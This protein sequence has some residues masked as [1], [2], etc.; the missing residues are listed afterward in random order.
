V[1]FDADVEQR[2]ERG[3]QHGREPLQRLDLH[4]VAALDAVD[5]RARNAELR[6]NVLGRQAAANAVSLEPASDFL[7]VG[8]DCVSES[9]YVSDFRRG[10]QRWQLRRQEAPDSLCARHKA[11]GGLPMENAATYPSLKDRV[12]LVTG[13]AMGIGEAIVRAF[14]R[15]Q[16]R[17]GFLDI[18]DDAARKLQAEI[19]ATAKLHYEHC[20]VTDI[21]ALRRAIENVRKA[22]GP[23]TILINNAAHDQ[24]HKVHDVTPE[25]WDDRMAVNLKHQFFAA[26]AVHADMKAAQ[27]GAIVNFGSSAW[28]VGDLDLTIYSTAK[29]AVLGLTRSLA[30]EFGPDNIRVNCVVPGWI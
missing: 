21:A 7:E 3:L 23:I 11:S 15:Q 28:I 26:Q 5:R 24:R 14:A 4:D 27:N 20:D 2:G 16:S 13:G 19:G 6:C 8:H 18:A 12:V 22:L 25:F 17:V 1:I 10:A 30:R 29:A 9:R